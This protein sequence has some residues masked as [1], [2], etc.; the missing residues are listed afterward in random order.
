[1]S[2]QFVEDDF[3]FGAN[4]EF[5]ETEFLPLNEGDLLLVFLVNVDPGDAP[6]PPAGWT[7]LPDNVAVLPDPPNQFFATMWGFYH[8]IE[9]GDTGIYDFSNGDPESGGWSANFGEYSGTDLVAPVTVNSK[10]GTYDNNAAL[11]QIL[12][13]V[14]VPYSDSRLLVASV[15]QGTQEPVVENMTVRTTGPIYLFDRAA[16]AG[17]TGDVT[18]T[19]PEETGWIVGFLLALNPPIEAGQRFDCSTIDSQIN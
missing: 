7:A 17:P 14:T 13:S 3:W 2:I 9:A 15:D 4:F 6:S 12:P 11:A 18:V 10:E 5:D 19:Y 16:A 8:I 1:M